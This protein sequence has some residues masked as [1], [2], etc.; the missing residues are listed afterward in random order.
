MPNGVVDCHIDLLHPSLHHGEAKS[1][2]IQDS[3]AIHQLLYVVVS[4][5]T[6]SLHLCQT[7]IPVPCGPLYMPCVKPGH[8]YGLSAMLTVS[9]VISGRH[10]EGAAFIRGVLQ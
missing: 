8:H 2:T 9:L 3:H 7:H 4:V 10:I 6:C 5:H 1:H